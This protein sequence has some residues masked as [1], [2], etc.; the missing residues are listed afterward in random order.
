MNKNLV[1]LAFSGLLLLSGSCSNKKSD[2]SLVTADSTA[3]KGA[4]AD[5]TAADRNQTNESTFNWQ[6]KSYKCTVARV[7]DTTQPAVSTE[8]GSKAYDNK[9]TVTI[10]CDRQPFF[11][12][13]FT[14]AD[15]K[16]NMSEKDYQKCILQGMAFYEV[17]EGKGICLGAQVGAPGDEEGNNPYLVTIAANG[18]SSIEKEEI[19]SSDA[20]DMGD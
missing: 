18:K 14:K 12:K 5:S 2:S 1:L 19:G 9:V 6:G 4:A 10:T 7:S 13:A 17:K 20:A 16:Q 15:F 8:T 11:E 3:A